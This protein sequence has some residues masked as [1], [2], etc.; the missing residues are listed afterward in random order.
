MAWDGDQE[1]LKQFVRYLNAHPNIKFTY[2]CS[3]TTVDFLD[4]TLYK[5]PRFELDSKPFF[6]TTNKF[7]YLEY[8]SAHPRNT[9]QSLIKGELTRLLRACSDEQ[10][11]TL[12]K[13]KMKVI[14]KDRGYPRHLVTRAIDSVPFH[15]RESPGQQRALPVWNVPKYTP[16][17]NVKQIKSILK[18]DEL[19]EGIIMLVEILQI[20]NQVF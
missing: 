11:Y 6:K 15:K 16:D 7:Q 17:L 2:E 19:E 5:G 13:K 8:T 12:I 1:S 4:L 18:P 20:H 10:Q 9:F 3:S 14:F